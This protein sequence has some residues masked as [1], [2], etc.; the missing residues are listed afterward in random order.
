[1]EERLT[2]KEIRN[3]EKVSK[4]CFNTGILLAFISGFSFLCGVSLVGIIEAITKLPQYLKI[5][6]DG[7]ITICSMGA[8]Y[9][10]GELSHE[11][12]ETSNEINELIDEEIDFYL[13]ND[14]SVTK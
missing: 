5:I 11:A 1:M 9:K 14:E 12:F 3:C 2:I 8:T 6:L 4:I 13:V 10:M 7:V